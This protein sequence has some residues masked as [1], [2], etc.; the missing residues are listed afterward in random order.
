[1]NDGGAAANS[2]STA[3]GTTAN[4]SEVVDH[5]STMEE[6]TTNKPHA[7]RARGQKK[8]AHERER[9]VSIEKLFK[10]NYWEDPAYASKLQDIGLM[11]ARSAALDNVFERLHREFESYMAGGPLLHEHDADDL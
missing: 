3:T 5:G 8:R 9:D 1:M 2:S 6:T 11:R 4:R 7:T 10:C